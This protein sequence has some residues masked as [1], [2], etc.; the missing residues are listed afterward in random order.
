MRNSALFANIFYLTVAKTI[1]RQVGLIHKQN[2]R[3]RLI[4]GKF[5]VLIELILPLLY[6][7]QRLH[8]HIITYNKASQRIA[9]IDLERYNT[10]LQSTLEMR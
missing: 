3:E 8:V 10:M 6:V 2:Y 7:L 1:L 5:H 4:I 9:V